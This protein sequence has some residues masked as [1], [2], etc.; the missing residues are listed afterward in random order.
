MI[1]ANEIFGFG[2]SLIFVLIA[3]VVAIV[4]VMFPFIVHSDLKELNARQDETNKLLRWMGALLQDGQKVKPHAPPA[5][6]SKQAKQEAKPQV[7]KL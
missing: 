1:A 3:L 5:V 6:P 4:W 2:L 7:Y